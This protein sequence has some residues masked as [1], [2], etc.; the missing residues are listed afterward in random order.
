MPIKG[1]DDKVYGHQHKEALPSP[2]LTLL[3]LASPLTNILIQQSLKH[4]SME[5]FMGYS[6]LAVSTK[7]QE[8]K[9]ASPTSAGSSDSNSNYLPRNCHTYK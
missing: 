1:D 6:L 4:F 3:L 9:R 8:R 5:N 7:S 2:I